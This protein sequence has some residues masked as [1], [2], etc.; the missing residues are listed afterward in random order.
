MEKGD[1]KKKKYTYLARHSP[2]FY[3]SCHVLN[4]EFVKSANSGDIILFKS[5]HS[6]ARLQ[7]VFTDSEYGKF[8][9]IKITLEL[10]SE[11]QKMKYLFIKVHQVKE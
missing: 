9:L 2:D 10:F 3:K 4:E 5:Q 7:R 8:F 6:A 11:T 1:G